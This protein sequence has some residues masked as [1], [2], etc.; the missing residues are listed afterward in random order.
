MSSA[1]TIR[2]AATTVEPTRATIPTS[3]T[4]IRI[5]TATG[6]TAGTSPARLHAVITSARTDAF[7]DRSPESALFGSL[8]PVNWHQAMVR[9]ILGANLSG[10]L[11]MSVIDLGRQQLTVGGS[12]LPPAQAAT[13]NIKAGA[14]STANDAEARAGHPILRPNWLPFVLDGEPRFLQMVDSGGRVYC[15]ISHYRVSPALW[16]VLKQLQGLPRQI[17]IPGPATVQ[18]TAIGTVVF[19]SSMIPAA[20]QPDGLLAVTTA[21]HERDECL[22]ITES[23]GFSPDEIVRALPRP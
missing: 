4:S 17:A 23:A 22:M 16:L 1:A 11:R 20:N 7:D 12:L 9:G 3:I 6:I 14:V 18:Q 2:H 19:V 15:T 5:S 10:G 13:V 21:Y 8:H